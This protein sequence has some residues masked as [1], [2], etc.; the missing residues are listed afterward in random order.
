MD[1]ADLFLRLRALFIR[2]RVESELDEELQFHIEMQT[3]SNLA[4]GMRG[5]DAARLARIQFG[6]LEQAKEVCRDT[7]GIGWIEAL[8]Q[9]IR[10]SI[11]GFRRAPGFALTVVATIALGLG[12][13]TTLFTVFNAYVLR[14]LAMRD[15]YSLYRFT[16]MN[17]RGNGHLFSWQEFEGFRNGNP[18]FTEVIGFERLGF[19]RVAGHAMFGQ[20]V[21]GNYF[22]MLGVDAAM[23]RPLFP[24]DAAA[25][26][27]APA[28]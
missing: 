12:L 28:E 7:R 6:G 17:R 5:H 25:P 1:W 9:D 11:R 16:W 15:P 26:G 27:G 21:S 2:R 20:L 14:P 3:R 18:A 23:G 10:Y 24:E 8:L 19:A 13:N 22:R 4:S